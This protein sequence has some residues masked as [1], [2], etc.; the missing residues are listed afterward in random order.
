MKGF[1]GNIAPCGAQKNKANQSQFYGSWF[2]EWIPAFA[3]M[4]K[5]VICVHLR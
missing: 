3:G 2:V 5:K 1:Y 4:T